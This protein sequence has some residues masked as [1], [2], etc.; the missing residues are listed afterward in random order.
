M[1]LAETGFYFS[2]RLVHLEFLYKR[3]HKIHHQFKTPIAISVSGLASC[4]CGGDEGGGGGVVVVVV[5]CL[6]VVV[7]VVGCGW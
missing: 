5:V 7:V 6:Y 1:L 2:H 4:C 3:I